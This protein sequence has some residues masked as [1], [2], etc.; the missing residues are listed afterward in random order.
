MDCTK[1]LFMYGCNSCID[2]LTVKIE[3]A[4]KD[5]PTHYHYFLVRYLNFKV[6][7]MYRSMNNTRHPN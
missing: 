7:L 6:F 3:M 4:I 5:G 1:Y 2:T